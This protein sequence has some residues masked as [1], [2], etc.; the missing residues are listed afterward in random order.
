MT[1]EPQLLLVVAVMAVG[2]L[3]TLVPDHWAPIVAIARQRGWSRAETA[4]AAI[5]AGIGH[6][7]STLLIAVAVWI[8]GVATATRLGHLVD[9]A[10]SL[11]LVGFGGWIALA[12]W[13]EQRW[14]VGHA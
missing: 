6:V 10:S 12:S 7:G 8:A 2:V 5:V 1:P 3:H 13:L 11:A 14:A 4:R 9:I